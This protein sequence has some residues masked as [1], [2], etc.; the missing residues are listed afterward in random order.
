VGL[1][2]GLVQWT[3]VE[4]ISSLNGPEVTAIRAKEMAGVDV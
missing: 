2:R 3:L 4:L 1:Q